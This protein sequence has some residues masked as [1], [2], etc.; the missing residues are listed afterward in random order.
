MAIFA[1]ASKLKVLMEPKLK[2]KSTEGYADGRMLLLERLP[3]R[4]YIDADEDKSKELLAQCSE[5]VI[6]DGDEEIARHPTTN[7][8]IRQCCSDIKVRFF[9]E[10]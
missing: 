7:E 4:T 3:A 9:F 10:K 2:K 6:D 1:G 8:E 5:L